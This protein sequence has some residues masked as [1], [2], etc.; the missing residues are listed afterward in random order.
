MSIDECEKGQGYSSQQSGGALPEYIYI[1]FWRERSLCNKAL[2]L[3][4]RLLKCLYTSVW[5]Y[6]M[7]YATIVCSFTISLIYIQSHNTSSSA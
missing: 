5:F 6:F 2:Y 7:P 3:V 1:D 4:Y